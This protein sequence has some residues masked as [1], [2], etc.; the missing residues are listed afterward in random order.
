MCT[1]GEDGLD[2]WGK[3]EAPT[4]TGATA[5]LRQLVE[6]QAQATNTA[7]T[8]GEGVRQGVSQGGR[9]GDAGNYTPTKEGNGIGREGDKKGREGEGRG[10]VVVPV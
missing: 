5:T 4:S 9:G 7:E 3:E 1:C 8:R 6:R 2:P 10:C